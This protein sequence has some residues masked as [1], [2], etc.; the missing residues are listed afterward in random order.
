MAKLT[1]GLRDLRQIDTEAASWLARHDAGLT[2]GERAAFE[3]WLAADPRHRAVWEEFQVPM[4][5][6][7]QVRNSGS[8]AQWID[9]FA[10]RRQQRR[11]TAWRRTCGAVL[12]AA[13]VVFAWIKYQTP[14]ATGLTPA[15]VAV[16]L[17]PS[18]QTL[19][20]GSVAELNQGA[21]IE[22]DFSAARRAV[23][24]VRGE[25]HFQVERDPARPFVVT[26]GTVEVRAVG[27]AFAVH[28]ASRGV[29][30]VV[31]HGRIAVATPDLPV[32]APLLADA[33][34]QVN[35]PSAA[36]PTAEP[37]APGELKR[38]L[39]WRAPRIELTG[40]A[41]AAA[42]P[43]FNRESPTALELGD[44]EVAALQMSGV[45]RADDAEGFAHM[46]ADNYGVRLERAPGKIILRS[47]KP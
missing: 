39:A 9:T 14:D 28:L 15:G 27:T 19:P 29:D 45:F 35:A 7:T 5:R 22:V 31:T 20:D 44:G 10:R 24:L 13:C 36:K 12:A 42:V 38:R 18:V 47:S 1:S 6:L 16:L 8:A 46:L 43:H 40:T 37:L 4:G 34:T 23:R 41:L 2:P 25:A 3:A 17:T 33:G 11:R 32:N 21:A 30:V 26:A